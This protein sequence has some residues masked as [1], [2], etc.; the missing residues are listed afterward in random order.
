ME[1]Y[2]KQALSM[3]SRRGNLRLL[4]ALAVLVEH[5]YLIHRE[6]NSVLDL[7]YTDFPDYIIQYTCI[8]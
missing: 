5:S 8:S 4:Q 7:D 3:L 6:I 2:Q 1:E